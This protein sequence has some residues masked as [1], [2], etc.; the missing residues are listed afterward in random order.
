MR[1]AVID[2]GTNTFNLLIAEV[3]ENSLRIIHSEKLP[4]LLGMDGINE[5]MIAEAAMARAKNALTQFKQKSMD[6][7]VVEIL[8]I[9]T[10][11][12]R[13]S[14]NGQDLVDFAKNELSIPIEIVSGTREAELIYKGV[15]WSFPFEE[16]TLI[17]DI[18]GGSTEFIFA[19]NT[20]ILDSTSLDIG[21]SRIYQWLEKPSVFDD[22]QIGK[23]NSFLEE[24]RSDF[25]SRSKAK[26]LLGTSGSFETMYELIFHEPFPPTVN[27]YELP[28]DCV[29]EQLNWIMAST[30]EE[31]IENPWIADIRKAMLPIAALK[32]KWVIEMME[33]ER[34]VVAPYSLKEGVF[35]E[36][37]TA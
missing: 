13:G 17:M 14:S 5:G 32:M 8:G 12:L 2:L 4:V 3:S 20:G 9:G 21:V 31:R 36:H 34:I 11:A 10:S 27:A 1:R 29:M 19:D 26:V 33:I 16:S 23:V 15:L 35:W 37:R 6:R 25:F 22:Q 7:E 24:Y 30:L 28:C 18:G